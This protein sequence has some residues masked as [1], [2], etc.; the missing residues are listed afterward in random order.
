FLM[1]KVY[2]EIKKISDDATAKGYQPV[3]ICSQAIRR[4]IKRALE[5][6]VPY[7]PVIS[8]Q[9]IAPGV[10]IYIFHTVKVE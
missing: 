4:F 10:K 1:E 2:E 5:R 7:L 3:V 9:E 8:P 6:V